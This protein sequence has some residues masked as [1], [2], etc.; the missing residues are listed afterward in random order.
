[1]T[2]QCFNSSYFIYTLFIL[3]ICRVVRSSS[4]FNRSVNFMAGKY[5]EISSFRLGRFFW[6]KDWNLT[7]AYLESK[8]FFR[9]ILVQ[10]ESKEGL[11]NHEVGKNWIRLKRYTVGR[12][13]SSGLQFHDQGERMAGGWI[14][15]NWA[16]HRICIV[17]DVPLRKKML[18]VITE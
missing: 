4:I 18:Q 12:Q 7:L 9:S 10:K 15:S 13:S 8:E 16:C 14:L 6:L 2:Y 5:S 1:M 11:E 3:P 17:F